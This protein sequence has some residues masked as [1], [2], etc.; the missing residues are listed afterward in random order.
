MAFHQLLGIGEIVRRLVAVFQRAL[1]EVPFLRSAA[2]I[3]END[4]QR[5][6]ALAEIITHALAELLGRARII[7]SVV[8]QLEG[9]AEVAA[10][11]FKGCLFAGRALRHNRAHFG[12]GREQGRCLGHDHL[13]VGVLGGGGI[14]RD[15]ELQHFALGDDA[16]GVRQD[17]QRFERARLHHH[18]EGLAEEIVAHQ[19][20]RLVAPDDACGLLAAAQV[21]LVDDV[22]MKQRCG[23]HELDRGGELQVMFTL[24]A[25]HARCSQGQHRADALAAGID[26]VVGDLGDQFDVAPGMA[27]DRLVHPLHVGERELDEGLD[28]RPLLVARSVERNDDSHGDCLPSL[29]LL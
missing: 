1:P 10:I 12:G 17:A 9:D 27:E 21:A 4:G 29:I 28:A 20:A 6:L 2:A 13:H 23:V 24:V 25:A 8:D 15:G 22:I 26:Q 18:L 16:G 11:G 3:G 5:D 19:H 14:L 7:Q